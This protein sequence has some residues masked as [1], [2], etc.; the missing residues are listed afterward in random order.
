M[1]F[2]H[3]ELH[4]VMLALLAQRPMHGY[5]LMGELARRVHR[6]RPSPGSIYPAMQALQNE[7]L[8]AARTDDDPRVYELTAE[9]EAALARRMPRLAALEARLGVRFADGLDVTLARF[10]ERVRAAAATVELA[11]IEDVL[12]RAASEIEAMGTGRTERL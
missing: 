4:L 1:R 11:R 5:E 8:I 10:G 12:G 7:G 3:G 6:Y 9:G 2:G